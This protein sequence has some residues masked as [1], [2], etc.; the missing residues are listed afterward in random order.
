[1]T[2]FITGGTGWIGQALVP[3]LQREGHRVR[4]LS[5]RSSLPGGFD[6][7]VELES[8]G[9]P[10]EPIPPRVLS[11]V[12][13]VINL[14]GE[15][16]GNGHWTARRKDR[17][18]TSRVE[19]THRLVE[20]IAQSEIKPKTLIS[21]SAVGYYGDRG[22]EPVT[23]AAQPGDDFLA[24]LCSHWEDA[25]KK[26]IPHGVRL[27]ILRLGVV[28]G[29]DGGALPMMALPFKLF[30]GGAL[31]SGR[32]V[33]SWVHRDDVIGAI[34]FVLGRDDLSGPIN[35]TAPNPVTNREF[36]TI[37]GRVLHRP[38]FWPMPAFVLR[39]GLG[40]MAD[41]ALKGQRVL[42]KRLQEFGYEFRYADV[43]AA[44]R[45]SL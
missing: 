1:M 29:K 5:R 34:R 44:L 22:D 9:G 38:S 31:G 21:A 15:S 25:A 19:T 32:Q 42:P 14:A 2:I 4:I 17:L 16:I 12:D 43:E 7:S 20:A 41:M 33:M 37:L 24:V 27:A 40:E 45:A 18:F 3:A 30:V 10:S 13:A 35:V 6:S 39:L 36:S 28:L 8:W 11:G 26:V 23:E